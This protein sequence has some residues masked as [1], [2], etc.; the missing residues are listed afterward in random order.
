LHLATWDTTGLRRVLCDRAIEIRERLVKAVSV[1]VLGDYRAAVALYDRAIEIRERLV[2]VEGRREL[3]NDLATA[4][5]CKAALVGDNR[6]A[7][8]KEEL[9]EQLTESLSNILLG[10]K[11][12]VDVLNAQTGEIIIPANRKITK[13]LLRKLARVHDHIEI[14]PSPTRDKI[15]EIIQSYAHR[16]VELGL[17]RE[18]AMS[19]AESDDIAPHVLDK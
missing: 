10:E 13:T 17:E 11:I 9:I 6:P 19:R 2:N 5:M 12:P 1:G 3:A 16:F 7:G 4:Y 14:D 18:N 8:K 15:R